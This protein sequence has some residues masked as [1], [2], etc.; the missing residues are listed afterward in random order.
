[1]PEGTSETAVAQPETF[2]GTAEDIE[3]WPY[4]YTLKKQDKSWRGEVEFMAD[5]HSIPFDRMTVVD[6][7]DDH[8][9]FGALF[10]GPGKALPCAWKMSLSPT[11]SGMQ[12]SL[13]ALNIEDFE[14]VVIRFEAASERRMPSEIT[15]A[16][17]TNEEAEQAGT[18]QPATRPVSEPEGSDKP[19]PEAE[20]QSR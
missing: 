4:R 12:A 18:G 20:G 19:Q 7:S 2:V 17:W 1:L 16:W 9:V 11:L 8:L 6:S 5:G 10:G 14:P 13:V 3:K 15:P